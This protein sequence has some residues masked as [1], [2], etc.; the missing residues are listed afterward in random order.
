[1]DATNKASSSSPSPRLVAALRRIYGKSGVATAGSGEQQFPASFK[2]LLNYVMNHPAFYA[3]EEKEATR[4][5]SSPAP[6]GCTSGKETEYT[7]ESLIAYLCKERSSMNTSQSSATFEHGLLIT[8]LS[9][10]VEYEARDE[11][12]P[13]SSKNKNQE[14]STKPITPEQQGHHH[15]STNDPAILAPLQVG[16]IMN[17]LEIDEEYEESNARSWL[18]DTNLISYLGEAAATYE[19][20]I[21]IQKARLW[22]RLSIAKDSDAKKKDSMFSEGEIQEADDDLPTSS[23]TT[24]APVSVSSPQPVIDTPATPDGVSINA[25]EGSSEVLSAAAL[26]HMI[27]AVTGGAISAHR[28]N[29]EDEDNAGSIRSGSDNHDMGFRVEDEPGAQELMIVNDIDDEAE[30]NL[31]EHASSCSSSS[32]SS[33]S[34]SAAEPENEDNEDEIEDDGEEDG[35]TLRQALAL[36]MLESADSYSNQINVSTND[37]ET[38]SVTENMGPLTPV[39]KTPLS[40]DKNEIYPESEE[41]PLPAMPT[42][43]TLSTN[44]DDI[45][46]LMNTDSKQLDPAALNAFG[47][48]PAANVVVQLLTHMNCVM[49]RRKFTTS[50][51]RSSKI[52]NKTTNVN[53]TS[54]GTG[55]S[56]FAPK[57]LPAQAEVSKERP[58]DDVATSLQLLVSIFLLTIDIRNDA[59]ENLKRAVA[60]EKQSSYDDIDERSSE[61]G[62]DPAI[63][64]AYIEEESSDSKPSLETLEDKG[65]RRKAAAAAQDAAAL[66]KSRRHR[67]NTW[68]KQAELFSLCCFLSMESLRRFLQG[69]TRDWLRGHKGVS[70]ADCHKL[71]PTSVIS[72]LSIGL[73]SLSSIGIINSLHALFDDNGLELNDTE[74][75]FLHTKLYKSSILLWGESV[76]IVYPSL[77]AQIEVLRSLLV[78]CSSKNNQGS[79][80][81]RLL[82]NLT[83]L[84]LSDSEPSIHRLQTL[85]RRLRVSDL[86]DRFVSGPTRMPADGAGS[87][88]DAGGDLIEIREPSCARAVIDEIGST[89]IL[90]TGLKRELQAIYLALCHRYHVR[91]LLWDG[92]GTSTD[93]EVIDSST[94]LTSSSAETF[95]VYQSES[96]RIQFD[97]TKC[98]DSMTIVANQDAVGSSL[99]FSS[100][101]QRASKVWGTVLSSTAFTPKTGIYRW[102]IRL[103]QCDRGHVFIGVAT[104]QASMRTYVGGDKY[105]WGMIGTQ[106]LWHDRRKVRGDY[107]ATFR[108]GSTIIVTLDTDAGTIAYSSWKDNS[109]TS[110]YSIDQMVQNISSPRRHGQGV[111]MVEDWGIAFE[112]LPLN[113]KLYPAVGLY[114]RDDKVTFLSVETIDGCRGGTGGLSDST[115]GLCYYPFSSVQSDTKNEMV[116]FEDKVRSFN[117]KVQLD[118]MQYVI[119]SL[120]R[121]VRS[122]R[123]GTDDFLWKSLLPSLASAICLFPRSIP[124]I[125]KRFGFTLFHELSKAILELNTLK[126]TD[127]ISRGLFHKGVQEGKW[128]IRATGSSG[129]NS[130]AEEY[131]VDVVASSEKDA[132]MGFEGAGVGTIGKSKNGLVAIV[133]TVK[134]SS[135]HFVEEWRDANDDGFSSITTEDSCSSCVVNARVNIDGTKFEGTY[136]NIQYGTTGT[137]AG[138]LCHEE[139]PKAPLFHSRETT[140]RSTDFSYGGTAG[141]VLLR[142]A[143]GHLAVII[144]ED[145]VDDNPQS[146]DRQ[147][148]SKAVQEEWKVQSRKL[149]ECIVSKTFAG[150]SLTSSKDHISEHIKDLK[151]IYYGS[152]AC[153]SHNFSRAL[154][155]LIEDTCSS[156]VTKT[157][158][159][160]LAKETVSYVET[161]DA[162]MCS[163]FCGTGS[164]AALC[165]REYRHAR[166]RVICAIVAH[167]RKGLN[168]ANDTDLKKI[169]KW[170]LRLMEDGVRRALSKNHDIPMREKARKCCELF[171]NVSELLISLDASHSTEEFIDVDTIGTDFSRLFKLISS[172]KDLDLLEEEFRRST[173]NTILRLIP[174]QHVFTLLEVPSH[175]S[176]AVESSL[177]VVPRL[178]DRGRS[179]SQTQSECNYLYD[180]LGCHYSSNTS[181]GSSILRKLLQDRVHELLNV[182]C[183]LMKGAIERRKQDGPSASLVSIDSLTLACIPCLTVVLRRADVGPFVLHSKLLGTIPLFLNTHRSCL[184]PYDTTTPLVDEQSSVIQSLHNICHAEVSRA[185]LRAIVALMHVISFQ[186]WNMLG[187]KSGSEEELSS[188][189]LEVLFDEFHNLKPLVLDAVKKSTTDRRNSQSKIQWE[190]F[191]EERTSADSV[192][193][194][195]TK[196]TAY[197]HEVGRSGATFLRKNGALLMIQP[198]SPSNASGTRRRTSS[199]NT[200]ETFVKAQGLL[201]PQYVSHWVHILVASVGSTIALDMIAQHPEW[202]AILLD[203][204]EIKNEARH[205]GKAFDPKIDDQSTRMP[206]RYRCRILRLLYRILEILPPSE[207]IIRNLL[208]LAGSSCGTVTSS[209]DEDEAMVSQETVSL[210]RRL[211]SPA[212]ASWRAC[213]NSALYRVLATEPDSLEFY[214]RV[215]ALCFLNGSIDSIKKGSRVLL[216]PPAAAPLSADRQSLSN[217]KSHS[218]AFSLVNSS[219]HHLVGNGTEGIVAG[220]CRYQSSAGIVSNIDAKNGVCEVILLS[221]KNTNLQH[222]IE[223]R[224]MNSRHGLTVR[225]LRSPMTD[226]VQAQEVPICIDDS[227]EV[228]KIV[229]SLL[230][231]SLGILQRERFSPK[232]KDEPT[233][234]CDVRSRTVYLMYALMSLRSTIT[235]LSDENIVSNFL[236]GTNSRNVLAKALQLAFPDDKSSEEYNDLM[237]GAN[238]VFLSSFPI[239]EVRLLHVLSLFH[240]LCLEA[241]VLEETPKMTWEKRLNDIKRI[242][243]R[244]FTKSDDEG[245]DDDSMTEHTR[246]GKISEVQSAAS[247]GVR[248]SANTSGRTEASGNRRASQSTAASD[249]SEEDEESEE[250]ATAAAHLR[251][252]AIAQMAELGL[253]RSWSEL[254]LRRTGGTN[255]EAAVHF[256]LERGGEMERLLAEERERERQSSGTRSSR[257]RASRMEASSHFLRQLTE[258][259]FPSRWCAE[260]LNATGNNVDEALTWILTNGERLSAEDE[261]MEEDDDEEDEED[262]D[263]D[264][265]DDDDDDDEDEDSEV[266]NDPDQSTY[267]KERFM[268][269]IGDAGENRC[270]L[271]EKEGWEGS[272][273]PLRFISG[274]SII[275]QKTL[276]VSG[277]PTGG[278]S[279]VGSKGVML[280]SGKWYYEAILE[281]AGCLQ[282][283][284]ADGS[285]A[286]HCHS[287]RGDGC[288]D[289][290]SSW[291]YDGWRRYRWHSMATEWGCRW[292]E[293]DVVGCLV[294]MDEGTVSFTLNGKAE[295]IGMGVAFS[296]QGFR[297]CGGVYA[298]VSFNRREKLRLIFGGSG[299]AAFKYPPP[300][301]Y[302]GVGE[303]VLE[304]VQEREAL[305][306]KESVLGAEVEDACKKRFLCDFSDGE[307]GHELM[308]WNHRYYGSEASVHLGSGRSKHSSSNPKSSSSL[309]STENIAAYCVARRLR[310]EW[311]RCGSLICS[312]EGENEN[313]INEI[314]L[315]E[316]MADGLRLAGVE[317]HKQML[318]EGMLLSSLITRKLLLHVV[319]VAGDNFDPETFL[320][321]DESKE[322]SILRFWKMVESSASLRSAGWIGEAGAMAITAEA[323]GLGI[324]STESLQSRLSTVERAGFVSVGDLD[325]GVMLPAGSIIQVLSSVIDWD[326]DKDIRAST[327]SS[328]VA[329]AE[330]ALGS[331]GGGGVLTFLLKGLQSSVIKSKEFRQVVVAC[332]RRSVRQLAVVEYENDDSTSPEDEKDDEDLGERKTKTEKDGGSYPDARLVSFLTGLLLSTPVA[333]DID[334]FIDIQTELFEAW[335]IGLLSASLPWR[336]ICA[337]TAAGIL[338]QC[339]RALSEVVKSTSTLSCYYARLRSTVSRR[340]WAERAAVPVCS[341]YSQAMVELLCSV[342]RA[343][344]KEDVVLPISF[345]TTWDKTE[346]DAATPLPLPSTHTGCDWEVQDGWVSSDRGWEIWT[347]TMKRFA[348]DWETPSRSAVRTLMEGG[349]GPPM[350]REGCIVIRGMDWDESK[351]GNGDGKDLYEREK[352]KRGEEK[353]KS[354]K[355]PKPGEQPQV[356]SHVNI[357]EKSDP[358]EIG[359]EENSNP[360]TKEGESGTKEVSGKKK[361]HPSLKLPIGTVLS[362]EPW[363]GIPGMARRVRW[364]TTGTEGI[365]RYGGDGGCYDISHIE[366]NERETRIRKRHPL[367]ESAEQCASRHGFGVEKSQSILLRLRPST[368]T[369]I[370][371]GTNLIKRDGILELPEF[372]SGIYVSCVFKPDGSFVLEE[373]HLLYGSKD[374]GWHARFGKPS[375]VAGTVTELSPSSSEEELSQAKIDNK[376]SNQSLFQEYTGTS[377]HNVEYLRNRENGSQIQVKSELRISRGRRDSIE[378]SPLGS[379][380][381]TSMP[382]PIRFDR[383]FH[384]SSLSLSRD[385]RTLSCGSSDGRG[386][387]FGN[388]GFSKGVHYW[389][390]K[391]EQAEIGSVFIGVAE[392][393]NENGSGSS[394]A[395]DSP[396]RLNKWHGWGFVNFRATYTAGSERIYGAH[397]HSGDV[398]GVLLDCDSGRIS[399]FYDGLK[400]G[401][402]ILNDLGCAFE[403]IS[404]F[405]FNVDGCGSGGAGQNAPSG[406][407]GGRSGRY[408]AQGSVRPRTLWPVV[409]LKNQGDRVSFSPKWSSSY[410][411]D[412]ASTVRNILATDEIINCVSKASEMPK[413]VHTGTKARFPRWFINEAFNEYARWRLNSWCRANTRENGPFSLTTFGLDIELDSSPLAC[414]SASALLGLNHALLSGDRVRLKRSAGRILELAEEAVVL[415]AYQGRLYYK[416]VSQKS[417][418]GSLTEGGGRAW[419]WD[420]SEVVDGLELINGSKANDIVLP[421]MDRFRCTS[422]GGLKV[423]YEDGAVIRS[424]L[425]IFEGSLNLGSIPVGTVIPKVDIL[426]RRVNACGVIRYHIRFEEFEGW[427][428]SKIRGGEEEPIV[429]PNFLPEEEQD[430]TEKRFST[431][432]ECAL[433]WQKTYQDTIA[434]QD[435]GTIDFAIESIA[436]FE[437]FA[438]EGIIDG[439]SEVSSDAFLARTVS[440]ICDF[441]EGGSP[442]DAPFHEVASAIRYAISSFHDRA[443][444][445][446]IF[447]C[448]QANRAASTAFELLGVQKLPSV[449]SIMA[450]IAMLRAFNRRARIALPWLSVRPCQEGSAILGGVYGYGASIDRARRGSSKESLSQWVQ[451]PSTAKGMRDVRGMLFTSVKQDL[452]RSITEATTTPTPISHDEYELPREIRTVRINRLRARRVMSSDNV[453]TKRKYS[454]FSQLQEET[455]AWGGS[456]FRRGFVAKGHGGQKRAFKMKLIGEGVNDYS[457][458]YR[459]AFADAICEILQVDA[460]GNGSLGV[461]DPTPN[462]V[463][464]IGENRALYMFSL[465]KNDPSKIATVKKTMTRT[466]R[467]IRSAFSTLIT[468]GDESSRQ[469]EEALVFLGRLAGTA[470]RHGIPL[471]LPLPLESVWKAMVEEDCKVDELK[472]I[473][474][475]AY[476]QHGCE[477]ESMLLSWQRRMLNSFIDGIS[478]V[479]PVE[480]FSIFTGEELRDMFCG[481]P[482]IDVDMLRKVV[483]Y[484]GYTESDQVIQSFWEILRELTNE[485]RKRFLQFVWAR[486]RLPLKESDFD[487]PFKI[488]KDNGNDGDQALPSASTCF[489]SLSLPA[490][491][492][493]EQLREKLLFAINNV[494]TMETDFQTNSA[495]ISE[496]YKEV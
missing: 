276:T 157:N 430:E 185:I 81:N 414:A 495:E 237:A 134:G 476:Q 76:P 394:H 221:R 91:V 359:T 282:I 111:G 73:A 411:V 232:R 87:E 102:A 146:V 188:S 83:S 314:K 283:G 348:V 307:H 457:G 464:D 161:M 242:M 172:M 69:V 261:G 205:E 147:L 447:S 486:N 104:A 178:L 214:A 105:G 354:E 292:A 263:G 286:G 40:K 27:S 335:S 409:G 366:V 230:A 231:E 410:G 21:E 220:L 224:S 334:D 70:A 391:L 175:C 170:S 367:P 302:R 393:P 442:L 320:E 445:G 3:S 94:S 364:H 106:A 74:S 47:S 33:S 339:P 233:H 121:I 379:F 23:P 85:S 346:M 441:C 116:P 109:S 323:L 475:L 469:V 25:I 365:Y 326:T 275:D 184:A 450:R 226:V 246:V 293:G 229:S 350:L 60:Q 42:P 99:P 432:R 115:V 195:L 421:L 386:T 54:G 5:A 324:S 374:S 311:A 204:I 10:L 159:P 163:K 31:E 252:A 455:K 295:E 479:L 407:E 217:S 52:E 245:I 127:C 317:M 223:Q 353:K 129:S 399:F 98:S 312:A 493:K 202:I 56:L 318:T 294:D 152:Q 150:A 384:A 322:N 481:N 250:A 380:T 491:R 270:N 355:P 309:K 300:V 383:D 108:T 79:I 413:N 6:A 389:E 8:I 287:D 281:T 53:V 183:G 177:V 123:E 20:R 443:F 41:S 328:L 39:T 301:G 28:E 30:D 325:E 16:S 260:A 67:T 266:S 352:E 216:K 454:V 120:D 271:V 58:S 453:E 37:A 198:S 243:E 77:S 118:G 89:S 251:E 254:A 110:S 268:T 381:E 59:I 434:S 264:D 197:H 241:S 97:G 142:L 22:K 211:Y 431:S 256:C 63:A 171:S 156:T 467:S 140:A 267:D 435:R 101:N 425:E 319:I 100:V 92:L 29:G 65:M 34:G 17:M 2:S 426:E 277:L 222:S 50:D 93:R 149:R 313:P 477:E 176:D 133:G 360:M 456:A 103:D 13:A 155:L 299:S 139:S 192:Q 388:I 126:N 24:P 193:K 461:L 114:Q 308:A 403:N 248:P 345:L 96:N 363:N 227:I 289:G 423:V 378:D 460:D 207:H 86:L 369:S 471:D 458:P 278:F 78:E 327:G 321:S 484:E 4:A 488:Q 238:D 107:G 480:I 144:G 187:S 95:R 132:C 344:A 236:K 191:C 119:N 148:G 113:A 304:R 361:K 490:Y 239:L 112:G 400:Y 51:E 473:D 15:D 440:V 190:R 49:G 35:I 474:F 439:Y 375:Y 117:D 45:D 444:D 356:D 316:E 164:L 68:K 417:E 66:L 376:F 285:F 405:G 420:E 46:D 341:R 306:S 165:P 88:N 371:D 296:G 206:A 166:H 377:V 189:C 362:I 196:T 258:M 181:G 141:R 478:S 259:G 18:V 138:L 12:D 71:L 395:H 269:S 452:L 279:S 329:S 228:G 465:N 143:H 145:L 64:L 265:D 154:D 468:A 298:C 186:A 398:I 84:P 451:L 424:D 14:A 212:H 387:A 255:I 136:H 485:E 262:V 72:K 436:S 406:I 419:F 44:T 249:Q 483:E 80:Q 342:T 130:D 208:Y 333:N 438:T 347:G 408:V 55:S 372:S 305:V 433:E 244:E 418:G 412:S 288:G 415:G 466:E 32:C 404:P 489:F 124:V 61:E 487:A 494:T 168:K 336:M 203:T 153:R 358:I 368:K 349:D 247:A 303:A 284:W 343:V 135:V 158:S 219:P 272:I 26:E 449:Q 496:G 19:D 137:I 180:Q 225:A 38:G 257:Q 167:L 1:M 337:L 416:I 151:E 390:V 290:P 273:I 90:S 122:V 402:H 396:P 280:T 382:S 62:D 173:R 57:I 310:T 131:V 315:A 125:S 482:D 492:S 274:R 385:N 463:S 332:I 234:L 194:T 182:I 235:L 331:G 7:L 422:S 448:L 330:A 392:K 240:R 201:I 209:I 215:G 340:L 213:I 160:L 9:V 446:K 174:I 200:S 370:E 373:K 459:E 75:V 48:I 162:E 169:W 397:C 429:I 297:P 427:I 43:P 462:N 437:S 291:A 210:L 357:E 338:N 470:F 179:G 11:E 128:I 253:P 428:S 401:E 82:D 218:S 36:S 472:E 351:Y 199:Q